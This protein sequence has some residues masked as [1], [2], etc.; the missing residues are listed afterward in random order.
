VTDQ[1]EVGWLLDGLRERVPHVVHAV[2]VSADGL[3]IAKTRDLPVDRAD[4]LSAVASGLVSLLAGAARAWEGGVISNLTELS[5]GYMFSMAVDSG[6]S[7]LVLAGREVDVGAVSFEMSA[8]IDKVGPA[9]TAAAR[10]GLP[11]VAAATA[12]GG[13]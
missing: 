7:L 3:L 2:A 10:D 12:G 11:T 9:L 4:I 5:V 8:L 1:I 6:A 13:R